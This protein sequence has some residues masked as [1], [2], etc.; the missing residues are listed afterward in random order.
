MIGLL[1]AVTV[2]VAHQNGSSG[3]ATHI[4]VK[5]E[6]YLHVYL[7]VASRTRRVAGPSAGCCRFWNYRAAQCLSINSLSRRPSSKA[8][9]LR[10]NHGW[11]RGFAL[12][13]WN[14]LQTCSDG[15]RV[16]KL[17][18]AIGG[19]SRPRSSPPSMRKRHALASCVSITWHGTLDLF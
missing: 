1:S 13:P 17:N 8:E 3:D 5:F 18:M 9:G 6:S 7:C 10:P 19:G 4:R 16:L 11:D 14:M 15:P 12:R 2:A